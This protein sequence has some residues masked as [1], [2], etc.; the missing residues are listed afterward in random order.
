MPP[1]T[2]GLPALGV[3]R[4]FSSHPILNT[5]T[6]RKYCVWFCSLA[7]LRFALLSLCFA[8][9]SQVSEHWTLPSPPLAPRNVALVGQRVGAVVPH[10]GSLLV[11]WS[12]P[13]SE[14]DSQRASKEKRD[15]GKS[16]AGASASAARAAT[17]NAAAGGCAVPARLAVERYRVLLAPKVKLHE[18]E[19]E[20]HASGG[21]GSGGATGSGGQTQTQNRTNNEQ[22]SMLAHCRVTV[23]ERPRPGHHRIVTISST[24]P[25]PPSPPPAATTSTTSPTANAAN[26]AHNAASPSAFPVHDSNAAT[27]TGNSPVAVTPN[28]NSNNQSSCSSP[29]PSAR[30]AKPAF[31]EVWGGADCE[32]SL[33]LES[34]LPGTRY[35]LRVESESAPYAH[36]GLTGRAASAPRTFRGGEQTILTSISASS[37]NS[38]SNSNEIEFVTGP[39]VPGACTRL[40]AMCS[41]GSTALALTWTRPESDGY[42]PLLPPR[43]A[44]QSDSSGSS[45][46]SSPTPTSA[47]RRSPSLTAG[48]PLGAPTNNPYVSCVLAAVHANS[49]ATP[50]STPSPTPAASSAS[51]GS[52]QP[53]QPLSQV[54]PAVELLEPALSYEVRV[55]C[56]SS[57]LWRGGEWHSEA[58]RGADTRHILDGLFPGHKY[59]VFLVKCLF[60]DRSILEYILHL[61]EDRE[62]LET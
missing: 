3:A 36:R 33:S 23:R 31:D 29:A 57:A 45:G 5:N 49:N 37:S 7:L 52:Q 38:N 4:V 13:P 30:D 46:S 50:P 12:A 21:S 28:S 43:P 32:C 40:R 54:A 18:R 55:R 56:V 62:P 24:A 9:L 22:F 8:L 10:A 25:L 14:C 15:K 53:S 6:L 39:E 17:S 19:P 1:A 41:L 51:T 58:T 35:M 16:S 27:G 20:R 44:R 26:A 47:A 60:D 2:P 61:R 11:R 48:L 42:S 34:L 59:E